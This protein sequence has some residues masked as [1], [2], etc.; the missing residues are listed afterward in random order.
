MLVRL[1]DEVVAWQEGGGTT[2]MYPCPLSP[3]L[4]EQGQGRWLGSDTRGSTRVDTGPFV[5]TPVI[6]IPT[7]THQRVWSDTFGHTTGVDTH[8]SSD[9]PSAGSAPPGPRAG[10]WTGLG[11]RERQSPH[12]SHPCSM[13]QF[14]PS[15][16]APPGPCYL[17]APVTSPRLR[18]WRPT[19]SRGWL[20]GPKPRSPAAGW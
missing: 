4:W 20:A 3:A 13:P 14:T 1:V 10:G 15:R 8:L 18:D 5:E 19:Y 6:S 17:L 16:V 7:C 11:A 9:A 12:L 2:G